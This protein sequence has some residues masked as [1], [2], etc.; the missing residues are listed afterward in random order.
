M[1]V[2]ITVLFCQWNEILHFLRAVFPS[3]PDI[4]DSQMPQMKYL[5]TK[6]E[7]KAIRQIVHPISIR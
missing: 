7:K 6:C 2:R 5:L 3:N 4:Y 1:G